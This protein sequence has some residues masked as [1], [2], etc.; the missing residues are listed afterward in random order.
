VQPAHSGN[1]HIKKVEFIFSLCILLVIGQTNNFKMSQLTSLLNVKISSE[2]KLV[3][4]LNLLNIH[5]ASNGT[6]YLKALKISVLT[7]TIIACE[8][9]PWFQKTIVSAGLLFNQRKTFVC[10]NPIAQNIFLSLLQF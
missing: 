8:N 2:F 1:D 7:S 10:V 5:K 9:S 6:T 4:K 3:K